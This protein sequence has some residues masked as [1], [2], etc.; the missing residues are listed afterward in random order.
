MVETSMKD[1]AR[2]KP[3]Y[4]GLVVGWQG[5]ISVLFSGQIHPTLIRAV[6]AKEQVK[7]QGEEECE[8]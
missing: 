1:F 6:P 7:S 5:L 3:T 2:D 8:A 4:P